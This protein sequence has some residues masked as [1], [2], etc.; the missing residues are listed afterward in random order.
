MR[1]LWPAVREASDVKA[2][3]GEY[4]IILLY[5]IE[6][7]VKFGPWSSFGGAY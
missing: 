2:G 3:R 4:N 5:I 7:C 1:V 6:Y